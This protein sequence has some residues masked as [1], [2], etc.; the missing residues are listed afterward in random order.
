M[1][2]VKKAVAHTDYPRYRAYLLR[3]WQEQP[4]APWRVMLQ[5]VEGDQEWRFC[6][7]TQCFDFIQQRLHK[8]QN[9]RA[10]P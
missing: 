1:P 2:V 10:P 5:E 3:L 6:D 9:E 8:E 4:G 7:T